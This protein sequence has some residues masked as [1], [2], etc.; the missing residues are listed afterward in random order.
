M[1]HEHMDSL[2]DSSGP[3]V[4]ISLDTIKNKYHN[5]ISHVEQNE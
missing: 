2:T 1:Q 5:N 3:I 4:E